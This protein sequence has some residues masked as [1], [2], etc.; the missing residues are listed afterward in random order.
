VPGRSAGGTGGEFLPL[1]GLRDR[2]PPIPLS[3]SAYQVSEPAAAEIEAR[4]S[5]T[6]TALEAGLY[7]ARLAELTKEASGAGA[8]TRERVK[9]LNRLGI[10]HAEFGREREAEKAFLDC[11]QADPAGVAPL[12]NLAA[13]QL[14]QGKAEEARQ[15]AERALQR[16]PDSVRANLLLAQAYYQARQNQ[17]AAEHFRVVQG[18]DP[19]LAARYAYLAAPAGSATRAGTGGG[20]ALPWSEE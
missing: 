3:E 8:K 13:L 15:V 10:L 1:A 6:L 14:T 4:L 20:Q 17:K 5:D 9:A 19:A 16:K 2:Y 12:L 7:Q 11:A 18:R